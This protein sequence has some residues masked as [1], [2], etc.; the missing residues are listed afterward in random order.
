MSRSG[1]GS[2]VGRALGLVVKFTY[3]LNV[4]AII[5]TFMLVFLVTADVTGR[6]IFNYPITGIPEII[7]ASLVGIAF[8][9]LPY[10]TRGGRQVRSD[11]AKSLLGPN[12]NGIM[13][14]ISSLLGVAVFCLI[15]FTNWND[16][17]EAWRIGEWEGQ[18]ALHVP[19]A[20]FRAILIVG[21]GLTAIFY[22][23]RCYEGIL[24]LAMHRKR[25]Q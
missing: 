20:P 14:I 1:I 18:G 17:I 19:T 7:Q 23:V 15:L 8:L 13:G 11:L 22:A 4:V 12:F 5:W 2:F 10:I 21:S 24:N 9:Y 25:T 3:G 6:F 16:M